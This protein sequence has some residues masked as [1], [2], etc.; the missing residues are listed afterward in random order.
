MGI[1]QTKGQENA[2]MPVSAFVYFCVFAN[3]MCTKMNRSQQTTAAV[4]DNRTRARI[5][6]KEKKAEERISREKAAEEQLRSITTEELVVH[7]RSAESDAKW[8]GD[9]HLHNIDV[10]VAGKTLV[11]SS[12]LFL[13]RGR[14]Y[15]LI[16]RNGTGK[17]TFLRHFFAREFPGIPSSCQI[18][19]VE[20]EVR[21]GEQSVLQ[22]L[23]STDLERTR[24]LEEEAQL[25]AEVAAGVK[26]SDE[27]GSRLALVYNQLHLIDAYSAEARASSML[28][29]LGFSPEM[30][31][32][33]TKQF[34]GGWRM[35][36]AL[37][38]ALFVHPDVLL[39]DEPTN[40]LDL[41]ACLWLESYLQQQAH[42]T[43][44]LVSH[45]RQFLNKV[46]TDVI[47]LY[48]RQLV[49]YK[50]DYDQFET[51][52]A[53]RLKNQQSQFESS[54]A[55][56]KHMQ[57]FI[58]RFRFNAKRASLVQSRLKALEKM[59]E[60]AEVISDPEIVFNFPTPEKL[61]PPIL[62]VV[63]VTFGYSKGNTL[64]RNLTFNINME[65]R[66]AVVGP[67]GAGKSTLI[68]L[69]CG[70][71]QPTDGHIQRSN[72]LRLALFSQ[73]HTDQLNMALNPIDQMM[74]SYP[75]T[76]LADVRAHLGKFGVIGDMQMQAQRTLSG[77]QKS[78]VALAVLCFSCPHILVLDEPTNHLDIDTIGALIHALTVYE[79]GVIVVSHDQH[80]IHG[81]ADELWV[82][83]NESVTPFKGDFEEYKARFVPQN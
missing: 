44:L 74:R 33:P 5:I 55:K 50:G 66:I 6:K 40:H 19:H 59:Q 80:L 3:A 49:A 26:T 81:I 18:L 54:D 13:S 20:Q 79:G 9:I 77:G 58:D 71:L 64:L 62:S 41:P 27:V 47:H 14:R 60:V 30:Q 68:K 1:R 57:Q 12:T 38:Q 4:M 56:R 45:D 29:G 51:T 72:K 67:N 53:Q 73:H 2:H 52:R 7:H 23:L 82:V 16:G 10:R 42:I 35:R 70:E 63:N 11:E 78:R 17:T 83:G 39:L 48:N 75:G 22:V 21:G 37:A 15:G 24:L 65:T 43:L 25:Q 8:N 46:V 36:V 34:S 61:N 31:K 32:M 28:S 69:I 76:Q